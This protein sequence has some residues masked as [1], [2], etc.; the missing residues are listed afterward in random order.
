VRTLYNPSVTPGVLVTQT[1][2]RCA[3]L[4][5]FEDVCAF[6]TWPCLAMCMN[7]VAL[8]NIATLGSSIFEEK[9]KEVSIVLGSFTRE[10]P[11]CS[12]VSAAMVIRTR[13]VAVDRREH[14]GCQER[15]RNYVYESQ[16][17]P[18]LS[19]LE[20][21]NENVLGSTWLRV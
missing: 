20:H 8:L 19:V 1:L 18:F 9:R 4:A 17:N 7:T 2:V 10:T 16:G 6:E 5:S 12:I 15:G 21:L 14:P 3:R 13:C 11:S